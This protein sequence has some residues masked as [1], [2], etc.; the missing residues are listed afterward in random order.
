MKKVKP[1]L[2]HKILYY[3]SPIIDED[4]RKAVEEDGNNN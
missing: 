4:I 2:L 3:C 1:C